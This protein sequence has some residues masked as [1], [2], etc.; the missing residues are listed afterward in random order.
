MID[1]RGDIEDLWRSLSRTVPVEGGQ[2][3]MFVA[4][5][6][7]DGT[8]SIA[9]SFSMLAASKVRR[10]AWL[11]DLDLSRNGQFRSFEKGDAGRVLGRPGRAYDASLNQA[12]FY[13]VTPQ[14]VGPNGQ[15]ATPKL[16]NLHPIGQSRLLVSRFR[17]ED[18][19]TGQRVRM[20]TQPAYWRA[21]RAA[22]DWTIVDAPALERSGAGLVVASQMDAVVLVIQADRTPAEDARALRREVEAH[23]GRCAGV[24]LNRT[25]GDAR[26]LDR[27]F[28]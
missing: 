25:G 22:A 16:L 15:V 27:L 14:A 24:V 2:M 7:G 19:R 6:E 1:L 26:L 3:V 10:A 11:I 28:G 18:L 21:V 8:S 9:A 5:R 17:N 20:R 23:G 13:S 12:Q 4:A